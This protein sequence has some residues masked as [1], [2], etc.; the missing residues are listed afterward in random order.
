[1][2]RLN[3]ILGVTLLE[4]MLVL[5]IV[6]MVIIMSVRYYQSALR[7]QKNTAGLAAVTAIVAAGESVLGAKGNFTSVVT[8]IPTFLPSN[9]MPNSPWTGTPITIGSPTA[10]SYQITIP[11][12]A[13]QDCPSFIVVLNTNPKVLGACGGSGVVI[14]VTE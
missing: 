8:D 2:K 3:R 4:T 12:S 14:T 7:S 11:M 6:A 10:S 5:A 9:T 1:M 13:T